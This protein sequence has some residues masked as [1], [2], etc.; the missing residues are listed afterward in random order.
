MEVKVDVDFHE[1]S[2]EALVDLIHRASTEMKLR[3]GSPGERVQ[4]IANRQPVLEQP[5]RE[6]GAIKPSEEEAAHLKVCLRL[7]RENGFVRAVDVKRY[8]EIAE[9]YPHY[10][11]IMQLPSDCR[12]SKVERWAERN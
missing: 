9:K 3:F 10:M 12:G 5:A 11:K 6:K 1:L 2:D 8:R 7:Y 4:V